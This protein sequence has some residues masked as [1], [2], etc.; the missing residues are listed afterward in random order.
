[1]LA[2]RSAVIVIEASSSSRGV[3]NRRAARL[4][5]AAVYPLLA[6][7]QMGE[8]S[9]EGNPAFHRRSRG[10][11][12]WKAH[13][14]CVP[15]TLPQHRRDRQ[16]SVRERSRRSRQ[17][18]RR[19]QRS[20]GNGRGVD[21][22]TRTPFYGRSRPASEQPRISLKA[23]PSSPTTPSPTWQRKS[24]SPRRRTEVSTADDETADVTFLF[25]ER[26]HLDRIR[27]PRRGDVTRMPST[28]A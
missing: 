18:P 6:W 3:N 21:Q 4:S 9:R 11:P 16:G 8:A 12:Q 19:S 20:T 26:H 17:T 15:I 14:I 10:T 2:A 1:M 27:T 13:I 23:P 25:T 22:R 24:S 7:L 5:R 28:A